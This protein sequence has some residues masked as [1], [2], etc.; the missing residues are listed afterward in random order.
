MR[1]KICLFFVIALSGSFL[2]SANKSPSADTLKYNEIGNPYVMDPLQDLQ[3]GAP[4]TWFVWQSREKIIYVSNTAVLLEYDGTHWKKININNGRV[5]SMDS[6]PTNTI[7]VA[8]NYDFGYLKADTNRKFVFESLLTTL[9]EP[10][11]ENMKMLSCIATSKGVYFISKNFIL[12]KN[13]TPYPEIQKARTE[14]IRAFR[15]GDDVYALQ[16]GIGLTRITEKTQVPVPGSAFLADEGMIGL[17][18]QADGSLLMCTRLGKFYRYDGHT[19]HFSFALS[20]TFDINHRCYQPVAQLPDGRFAFATRT[21]GIVL[22][23]KDGTYISSIDKSSG[24]RANLVNALKVDEDGALWAALDNGVNRVEVSSPLTFMDERSGLESAVLRIVRHKGA[25]YFGTMTG[26]YRHA[27]DQPT[28]TARLWKDL[29]HPTWDLYSEGD[30]LLA[31]T[32]FGLYQVTDGEPFLITNKDHSCRSVTRSKKFADI[33]YASTSTGILVIRRIA[34]KKWEV[35]READFARGFV[36]DL[37]EDAR[38]DLWAT[39][40]NDG[41]Y[42]VQQP[43]PYDSRQL[44]TEPVVQR[45]DLSHGLQL[46]QGNKILDAKGELLF[47]SGN[48]LLQYDEQKNKFVQQH[49]IPDKDDTIKFQVFRIR[50]D[51]NENIYIDLCFEDKNRVVVID[52]SGKLLPTSFFD[53]LEKITLYDI[54]IDTDSIVWLGGPSGVIRVDLHYAKS[55]IT[56][57]FQTMV[58]SVTL[59]QDSVLFGGRHTGALRIVL[60]Y[61]KNNALRF[62]FGAPSFDDVAENQFQYFLEGYSDNWSAWTSEPWK[63]YTGLREGHYRM[64][65]RAK[66][67]YKVLGEEAILN[68]VILPPWY[69]TWWAYLFYA[70]IALVALWV[71]VHGRLRQLSREKSQLEQIVSDRTRELADRNVQ[72]EHQAQKLQELDSLKS[73]FFA[74]ISHEFRTPLSLILGPLEQYVGNQSEAI[75]DKA[76]HMMY[77]NS[78]RL[79]QLIDQLLYITKLEGGYTKLTVAQHDLG[80]FMRMILPGFNTLAAQKKIDFHY[81]LPE[82]SCLLLLD[83]DKLEKILYNL[84]S[85]AFKFTHEG[86]TVSI[87]VSCTDDATPQWMQVIVQDSGI[88]IHK[89]E[90][91]KIFDRFYRVDAANTSEF[92][93]TGI[94]LALVKELVKLYGGTIEVTSE[95]EKGSRFTVTLP[96]AKHTLPPHE[97]IDFVPFAEKEFFADHATATGQY[98]DDETAERDAGDETIKILI[99][100]D[101]ADLYQYIQSALKDYCECI[102]AVNGKEGMSK[103]LAIIPDLVITDV[104]MPEVDGLQFCHQLKTDERTSHIPVIMLTAKADQSS[105]IEGLKTGADDYISKPFNLEELKLKV[106]NLIALRHSLR[107]RYTKE[108]SVEPREISITS[109]DEVF[110]K[111]IITAIEEKMFDPTFSVERLVEESGVS[112]MQLHRKL[113]ALTGQSAGDLIR[114]LRLKRAAQLLKKN[115]DIISQIGYQ[116]GFSDPSYFARC[117]RRQ[118]GISPSDYAS[119]GFAASN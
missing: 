36:Q 69:R 64:H 44:G 4:Q 32:G 57:A 93:G 87:T 6:D 8:T 78:K 73:Q 26:L 14:I 1:K 117:F 114:T 53:R 113:K 22:F 103:A 62:E 52:K 23:S 85:N 90:L 50:E 55:G 102:P 91:S 40:H 107:I 80:H 116:V 119:E 11:R 83:A 101:N 76:A 67:V 84:L 12:W 13:N 61:Q 108:V 106:Q 63:D 35:I 71:F 81:I 33:Y 105:K 86:G 72:L 45:Y 56:P 111:K 109:L 31:A 15:T 41:Y 42:K 19:F 94:G 60:P 97:V 29:Q 110:L 51:K 104:M 112:R 88:G 34:D 3:A 46:M 75:P 25:L 18:K 98:N 92:S 77:R 47:S 58:R 9:P 66:N 39:A 43:V 10:Y 118:F 95:V 79:H 70:V 68:I 30:L 17:F 89:S 5:V 59:N 38:G 49:I 37:K 54:L 100:E 96:A 24:L 115:S 74:N 2:C 82:T 20:R 7:Y 21:Q 99:A 65:V 16:A 48:K 28:F 27:P